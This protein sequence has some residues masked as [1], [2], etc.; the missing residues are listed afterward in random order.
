MPL[1]RQTYLSKQKV[2]VHVPAYPESYPSSSAIA[3]NLEARTNMLRLMIAKIANP[4]SRN[5]IKIKIVGNTRKSNFHNRRRLILIC[6]LTVTTD[7]S[8]V[9]RRAI[10]KRIV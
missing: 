9:K 6:L 3:K 5:V 1:R 2:K 8:D 7:A 4:K 10:V